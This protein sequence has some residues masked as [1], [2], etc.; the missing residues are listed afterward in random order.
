MRMRLLY[1][2]CSGRSKATA[3]R[4][5]DGSVCGDRNEDQLWRE[6]IEARRLSSLRW[7]TRERERER[8]Y[9]Q[10]RAVVSGR[11]SVVG[12]EGQTDS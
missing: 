2:D 8:D 3:G 4:E 9:L 6:V 5:M 12:G 10:C 1:S 11:W 7:K